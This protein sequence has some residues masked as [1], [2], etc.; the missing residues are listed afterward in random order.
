M[1]V[2]DTSVLVA[3][4][5]DDDTAPTRR[6]RQIERQ[7]IPYA[8]PAICCQELL[9]GAHNEREWK[10]L[11][12]YLCTQELLAADDPWETHAEAARIYFDCR[13]EGLTIGSSIDCLIAQLVLESDGLLLHDDADFER[14]RRVRPLQTLDV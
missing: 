6:L 12:R 4:F 3:F 1:I 10:L 2:V 8:I 11:W 5:R 7:K 13:R 14:I 9:Q